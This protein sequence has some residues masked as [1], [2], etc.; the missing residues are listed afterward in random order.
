MPR[1]REA[2]KE[3]W[4]GAVWSLESCKIRDGS[5]GGI[6]WPIKS[7]SRGNVG[8][9]DAVKTSFHGGQERM[10]ETAF[11]LKLGA[12]RLKWHTNKNIQQRL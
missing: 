4:V 8:E 2:R 10:D 6:P 1:R 3:A 11:A 7:N 5:V 9:E 12:E